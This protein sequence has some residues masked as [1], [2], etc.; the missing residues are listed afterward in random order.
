MSM[1]RMADVAALFGKKL[2][3]EFRIKY[4]EDTVFKFTED[5]LLA[6]DRYT[7]C[8]DV[9]NDMLLDLI[10]GGWVNIL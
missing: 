7:R 10:T 9:D 1:N 3:E 4:Y 2:G 6:I 5:G 8:S